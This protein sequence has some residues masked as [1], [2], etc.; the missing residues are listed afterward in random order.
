MSQIR[1]SSTSHTVITV[2]KKKRVPNT[3]FQHLSHCDNSEKKKKK[4]KGEGRGW[5]AGKYKNTNAD[6]NGLEEK[7]LD[8]VPG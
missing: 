4:K 5:E 6:K 3:T 7:K 8:P 2:K 1:H